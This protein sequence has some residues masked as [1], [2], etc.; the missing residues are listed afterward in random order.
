MV[1]R[2]FIRTI[3]HE[4][5]IHESGKLFGHRDPPFEEEDKLLKP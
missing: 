2:A 3:Y 4:V 1:L 5:D